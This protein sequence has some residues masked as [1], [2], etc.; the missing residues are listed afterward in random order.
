M[1]P[2][3]VPWRFHHKTRRLL[4]ASGISL[5]A[6]GA[7]LLVLEA[8][9]APSSRME[10]VLTDFRNSVWM[11]LMGPRETD[12]PS[13]VTVVD[14]DERT[15][16]T[17][18][19]YGE[20]YRAHHAK[21]VDFLAR[22]GAGAIVFDFLFKTSDSG[23]GALADY[24]DRL[25]AIGVDRGMDRAKWARLRSLLDVSSQLE[26]AVAHAPRVVV[27]SQLGDHLDYPNPSDWIPKATLAWQRSIWS[28]TPALG[29][30][31]FRLPG[32]NTLDNLYP[33]LARAAPFLGL[34]NMEPDPDGKVRRLQLL[35]RFPDTS[36]RDSLLA[37]DGSAEPA[38]YPVLALQAS[39]VLLG[40]SDRE[41][42]FD[43]G[44]VD[45][46]APLRIWKD[47][48]GQILTSL[49]ALTWA[50]CQ[51]LRA[52][53]PI[54]EAL[55]RNRS[56]VE[57]P[58][59]DVVID[60]L[61]DGHLRTRLAYP[62]TLD[63]ATT[64][65]LAS[66]APDTSW[67]ERIPADGRPVAL[68]DSVA[69]RRVETGFEVVRPDDSGRMILGTTIPHRSLRIFL[70]Q[71]PASLPEGIETLQPDRSAFLSVWIEAWWDRSRRRM[72]TS[73]LGLRGSSL[74]ALLEL[75]QLEIDRL[76]RGDTIDLGDPIRIPTD[77][78]GAMLLR[79]AA[80]SRWEGRKSDQAWIRH[81][82]YLDFLQG[83]YDPGQIPGRVFVLGSSAN[84]LADFVDVPIE[85]RH[86]GVDIQAL[87]IH[88]I[89]SGDFLQSASKP[90]FFVLIGLMALAAGLATSS[91]AP[92]WA[93]VVVGALVAGWFGSSVVAFDRGWWLP[94]FPGVASAIS[95]AIAAIGLRYLLEEKQR[96]FLQK[97]FKTYISPDLIDQMIASGTHPQLGG[98]ERE[99]TAFFTDIQGFST[100]SEKIGSPK[101]LVELINEY[102]SAMT[103]ILT[104]NHGTLDKYIGDAIVAMFG[105]PVGLADH[106]RR[107]V[108]SAVQMQ[109]RLAELRRKWQD[110]G[111]KWPEI[112]HHMRMRIG[113]NTGSIV[114]GNM[115][116]E[117]RM[118]YTM[119]G[120]DVN[121]AARLESASKQYGIFILASEATVNT[122]G[123]GFVTREIDRIRVMGKTDPVTIHEILGRESSAP[124]S[125]KRCVEDFAIARRHYVA[126]EFDKAREGFLAC[127]P[128]E[129]W[130]GQPGVHSCPSKVFAS[131]CERHLTHP[132]LEWDAVY[133]ATE[134]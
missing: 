40:R 53:R 8:L 35:W 12:P 80:P 23:T 89:L 47:D 131:R 84:A 103:H 60:R 65:A 83:R 59:V 91:L 110:E 16:E 79:F 33:A 11:V 119:M 121:L 69:L 28:G 10:G 78:H 21:I 85:S 68:D 39:L 67:M 62:D 44:S 1:S 107:A 112:V 34:A 116:S 101:R 66:L 38:A 132:P 106:A 87:G 61:P 73:L 102:L 92:G 74:A 41:I 43:G 6:A 49:P 115:G 50:M 104:E 72:A 56:G 111:D 129:P 58:T 48:R 13:P 127:Q 7:T 54:L 96:L 4:R 9:K 118:N 117:L 130:Y 36:F 134:K 123:R 90:V 19:L 108:E 30:D 14:V 124:P 125:W 57:V 22:N 2:T 64:R 25:Q 128:L 63:D 42:R 81:V 24:R 3:P 100:F 86:P 99:I 77:P 97:S 45:I 82:S 15:L 46:G 17:V 5:L 120:D 94:L 29:K 27:A 113:L 95:A 31:L 133:T 88:D 71:L 70:T 75:P 20:N 114:T 93:V 37:P 105:A 109:E 52:K 18:G 51:D 126:G 55:S 76:H 98:E 26:N 32:R 122:A